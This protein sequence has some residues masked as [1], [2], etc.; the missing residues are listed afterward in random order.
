VAGSGTTS[1]AELTAK[2]RAN[3]DR[4]VSAAADLMFERGVAGTSVQD[5][6]QAGSGQAFRPCGAVIDRIA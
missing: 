1:V 2:G 6:Q 3:R 5:V 4:I